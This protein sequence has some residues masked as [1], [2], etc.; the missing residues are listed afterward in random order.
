MWMSTEYAATRRHA[1][2]AGDMQVSRQAH[3]AFPVKQGGTADS[4]VRP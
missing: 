4:R 2:V 1:S 3:G